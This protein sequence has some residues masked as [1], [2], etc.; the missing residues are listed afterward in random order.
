MNIYI[1]IYYIYILYIYILYI[2]I[3]IIFLYQNNP[4]SWGDCRIPNQWKKMKKAI[5]AIDGWIM[6]NLTWGEIYLEV[7]SEYTEFLNIS[8]RSHMLRLYQMSLLN[9]TVNRPRPH[10]HSICALILIV[11]IICYSLMSILGFLF[12]LSLTCYASFWEVWL[13]HPANRSFTFELLCFHLY[14]FCHHV[15]LNFFLMLRFL[16]PMNFAMNFPTHIYI[17]IIWYM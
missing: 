17:Y 7:N 3:Y 14:D 12:V 11:T 16:F 1:Y 6:V 13:L 2:Y 4:N 9:I 15:P 5:G 10:Q 8:R